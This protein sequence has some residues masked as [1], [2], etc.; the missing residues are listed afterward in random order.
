MKKTRYA[1]EKCG[2]EGLRYQSRNRNMRNISSGWR[3]RNKLMKT[4]IRLKMREAK[5]KVGKYGKEKPPC[6]ASTCRPASA[7][8]CASSS[9]SHKASPSIS[10]QLGPHHANTA[11]TAKLQI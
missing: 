9:L 8:C 2:R 7:P 10:P 5:F 3:K 6:L 1:D 11:Y 4:D